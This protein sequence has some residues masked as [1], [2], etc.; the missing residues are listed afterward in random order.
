MHLD[1]TLAP[2]PQPWTGVQQFDTTPASGIRTV[3]PPVISMQ[4]ANSTTGCPGIRAWVVATR[5]QSDWDASGTITVGDIFAFL[6][7]W[8]A[9]SAYADFNGTGGVQ[10]QDIFDFL[11]AWFA[12]V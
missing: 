1:L 10:V 9:G 12:G 2:A 3:A 7:G 6:S 4:V 5:Y 11:G 8:F